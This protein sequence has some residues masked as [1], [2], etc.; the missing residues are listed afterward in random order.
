MEKLFTMKID[1][2]LYSKLREIA[3][4]SNVSMGLFIRNVLTKEIRRLNQND[5]NV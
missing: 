4:N 5:Q 2:E 3:F 1:D